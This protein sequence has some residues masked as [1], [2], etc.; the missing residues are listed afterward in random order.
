MPR[1]RSSPHYSAYT[2]ETSAVYHRAVSRLITVVVVY[3][4]LAGCQ[5]DEGGHASDGGV[6]VD[7]SQVDAPTADA[8]ATDGAT[9]DA[10]STVDGPS[11][12]DGPT[13]DGPIA[14]DA[15]LPDAPLPDA[16]L[17]RAVAWDTPGPSSLAARAR[18]RK[19]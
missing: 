11:G 18:P 3:A 4:G 14:V 8:S 5:F 6:S 7:S 12:V 16:P 9:T 15:S 2:T 10:S 17:P 1:S 13:A 19:K